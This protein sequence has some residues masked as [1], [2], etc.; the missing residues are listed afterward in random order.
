MQMTFTEKDKKQLVPLAR[1]AR[2]IGV[3]LF[4]M[5]G[6]LLLVGAVNLLWA[7][8]DGVLTQDKTI[9]KTVELFVQ[10][11]ISAVMGFYT[12]KFSGEMRMFN[13]K[14]ESDDLMKALGRLASL[15]RVQLILVLLFSAVIIFSLAMFAIA[16]FAKH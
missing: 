8:K 11:L 14:G 15:Y 10:A 6:F 2:I 16:F 4:V 5:A 3:F 9:A 7:I 1:N 12:V 13:A